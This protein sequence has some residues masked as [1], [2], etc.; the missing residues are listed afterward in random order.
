M[1]PIQELLFKQL[2]SRNQKL[3]L[4]LL[5]KVIFYIKV[6]NTPTKISKEIKK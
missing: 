1:K 2:T 6:F 4:D 5:E 3:N